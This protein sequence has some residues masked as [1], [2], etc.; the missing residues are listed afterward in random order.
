MPKKGKSQKEIDRRTGYVPPAGVIDMQGIGDTYG[1]TSRNIRQNLVRTGVP[2]VDW[3]DGLILVSCRV[4]E[5]A[6]ARASKCLDEHE[7]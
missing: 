6:I 1:R 7:A 5:D 3:G 4:F 2:C